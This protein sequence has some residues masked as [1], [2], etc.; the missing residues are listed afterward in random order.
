MIMICD[1]LRI[2]GHMRLI[3]SGAA[4]RKDAGVTQVV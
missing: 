4:G 1:S 3:L 2:F